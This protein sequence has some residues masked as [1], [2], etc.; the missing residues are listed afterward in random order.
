M[1][2]SKLSEVLRRIKRRRTVRR[3]VAMLSVVILLATMNTL[4][5]EADTLERLAACGMAEHLHG[6]ECYDAEGTL[7]CGMTEHVH[8]DAC[9]QQRPVP[10]GLQVES[11]PEADEV[12]QAI[13]APAEE[14]TLELGELEDAPAMEAAEI[15]LEDTAPLTETETEETVFSLKDREFALASEI[16][17]ACAID[18]ALVTDVGAVLNGDEVTCVGVEAINGDWLVYPTRDFE[19][20]ELAFF[21]DEGIGIVKLTDGHPIA[22]QNTEEDAEENTEE[23]AGDV[24]ASEPAEDAN[25]EDAQKDSEPERSEPL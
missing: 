14:I 12:S 20:A 17:S 3:V 11:I 25:T 15:C 16:A 8:T 7:I 24:E 1:E 21:I 18:M 22:A 10:E 13:E 23:D 19:E 2:N 9:F 6:E 5:K 4:K